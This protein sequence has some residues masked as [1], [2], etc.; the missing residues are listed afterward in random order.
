MA[1][2]LAVAPVRKMIYFLPSLSFILT[3]ADFSV[4]VSPSEGAWPL[5]LSVLINKE[6]PLCLFVPVKEA[7][8]LR[9]P[10]PMKAFPQCLSAKKQCL[11]DL[12]FTVKEAWLL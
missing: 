10:V 7:W 11:L 8:L 9:I 4:L 2:L 3:N 5:Y 1:T 6:C 12:P